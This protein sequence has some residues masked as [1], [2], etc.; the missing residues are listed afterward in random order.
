M[1][2]VLFIGLMGLMLACQND[3]PA[4]ST[5]T[6]TV[7]L[8]TVAAAVTP[9]HQMSIPVTGMSCEMA[10]GG[11]IRKELLHTAAVNRVQFDF[12]MARDTNTAVIAYDANKIS[13]E[14]LI[15]LITKINEGQFTTGQAE[16]TEIQPAA[17]GNAKT[18]EGLH[19]PNPAISIQLPSI[20][21]I[22]RSIVL[23]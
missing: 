16:T 7:D 2:K 10:C 23:R 13:E 15:A 22:L 14:Q 18:E 19:L 1:K 17:K 5:T 9:T 6:E 8:Q 4:E 12:K 21:D 11:A 20:I 3:A